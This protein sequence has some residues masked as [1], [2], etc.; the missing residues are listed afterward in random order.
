M[1]LRNRVIVQGPFT[2]HKTLIYLIG[3]RVAPQAAQPHNREQVSHRHRRAAKDYGK[4]REHGL[5]GQNSF[6]EVQSVI[7]EWNVISNGL[8]KVAKI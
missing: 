7:N 2:V 4:R 8:K 3:I 5:D 6:S 1:L